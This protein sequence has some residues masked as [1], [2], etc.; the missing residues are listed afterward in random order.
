MPTVKEV[1]KHFLIRNKFDGLVNDDG[2]C[3]CII[4]DLMPCY[5]NEGILECKAGYK[6]PCDCGDHD[7]HISTE[8]A[9]NIG[10][11]IAEAIERRD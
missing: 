1:I 2:E 7:F 10:R 9:S 5:P 11:D 6:Q 3:G 8:K 4:D